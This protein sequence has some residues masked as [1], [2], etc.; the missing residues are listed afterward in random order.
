MPEFLERKLKAEYP[1]NPGAVYGTLNSLGYM[2]GSRETAKGRAA[3]AK[4]E[5]DART[6]RAQPDARTRHIAA[7]RNAGRGFASPLPGGKKPTLAILI[8]RKR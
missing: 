4:H 5:R 2:K 3:Q 7:A 8:G 6:S 1:G